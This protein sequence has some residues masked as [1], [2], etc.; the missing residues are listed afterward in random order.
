MAID[1]AMQI[2]GGN[3]QIFD[4]MLK[5]SNATVLLNNTVSGISKQHGKYLIKSYPNSAVRRATEESFDT[6]VMAA[7]LQFSNIKIEQGLLDRTPDE[8][9]YVSL[10]VTLFTSLLTLSP[11]FFNLPADAEVPNTI[12]TTL[13]PEEVPSD[14]SKGAGSPG[15]FSIS[16]LRTVINPKTLQRENLYKIFSPQALDSEFLSKLFREPSAYLVSELFN[17]LSPT[18]VLTNPLI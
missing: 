15:F 12:L 10:H 8:I 11:E 9:P 16:T 14:P 3:W 6:V 18:S 4:S 13:T 17:L 1:G 2:K 7:P 5:E